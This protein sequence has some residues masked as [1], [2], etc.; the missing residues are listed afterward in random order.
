[1][2]PTLLF[3]TNNH[4]KDAAKL[5]EA[6]DS[7]AHPAVTSRG[8][9]STGAS[10]TTT[11]KKSRSMPATT[12]N[13]SFTGG[14]SSPTKARSGGVMGGR[15]VKTPTKPRKGPQ[16]SVVKTEVAEPAAGTGALATPA[17][18][19]GSPDGEE[20]SAEEGLVLS[21]AQSQGMGSFNAIDFMGFGEQLPVGIDM[22]MEMGM[23]MRVHAGEEQVGYDDEEG[24]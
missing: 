21:Q 20:V 4:Q 2:L 6:V 11:P 5:R 13:S 24:F 3:L 17:E 22:G 1:M 16:T 7:G 15:V 10:P 12:P 8:K 23:D 19:F 18:S 14:G 9:N